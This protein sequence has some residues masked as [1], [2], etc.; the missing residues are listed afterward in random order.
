MIFYSAVKGLHRGTRYPCFYMLLVLY[1]LFSPSRI[2]LLGPKSGMLT[3]FLPVMNLHLFDAG[4]ICFFSMDGY[5][6]NP[7]KSCVIVNPSSLA[8]AEQVFG[9]LA[10]PVVTSHQF[11]GGFLGDASARSS[12][13]SGEG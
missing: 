9:P 6:P 4:L 12:F 3:M 2:L 7:L 13:C 11:L 8:T 1:L 5:F 10:I